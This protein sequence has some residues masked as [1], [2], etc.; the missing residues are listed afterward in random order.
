MAD[1]KSVAS[2]DFSRRKD[3]VHQAM[4]GDFSGHEGTVEV[5]IVACAP[6]AS[7]KNPANCYFGCD[8][9]VVTPVPKEL[10][11][12]RILFQNVMYSGVSENGKSLDDFLFQ[13]LDSL[14]VPP[15]ETEGVADPAE[16]AKSLVGRHGYATFKQRLSEKGEWRPE[17]SQW[18]LKDEYDRL[19]KEQKHVKPWKAPT[20]SSMPAAPPAGAGGRVVAANGSSKVSKDDFPDV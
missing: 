8:L 1:K 14:A 5:E 9:R 4:V 19:F 10:L 7:Q 18:V 12:A 3:Y 11:N 2:V 17:V 13:F 15:S 6:K 20:T 16:F